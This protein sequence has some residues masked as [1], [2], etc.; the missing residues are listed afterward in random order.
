MP[1]IFP[2]GWRGM[3]WIGVLPALAVV[4]IRFYVKEPEVWSENQANQ[5][6]HNARWPGRSANPRP[7]SQRSEEIVSSGIVPPSVP[8]LCGTL[9]GWKRRAGRATIGAL[10]PKRAVEHNLRHIAAKWTGLQSWDDFVLIHGA[11]LS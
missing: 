3:L 7:D 8:S 11:L 5:V 4:W 1:S 9:G 6:K 2:L 10:H